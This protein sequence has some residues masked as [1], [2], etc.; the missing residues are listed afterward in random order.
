M[1]SKGSDTQSFHLP[2]SLLDCLPKSELT[3]EQ[4]KENKVGGEMGAG[5]ANTGLGGSVSDKQGL[6]CSTGVSVLNL[7]WTFGSL[8]FLAYYGFWFLQIHA[9]NTNTYTN[10]YS[11]TCT[12]IFI[13]SKGP[14]QPW[15]VWPSGL[16]A[17][18]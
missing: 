11:T 4:R 8:N 14:F 1:A 12:N 6:F 18:L 17:G 7:N 15:L 13:K 3:G 9:S 2:C 10:K 16:S 5:V